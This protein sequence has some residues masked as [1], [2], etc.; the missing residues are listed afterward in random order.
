[1]IAEVVNALFLTYI[2]TE[3]TISSQ[4]SS[5]HLDH[6][7][8]VDNDKQRRTNRVLWWFVLSLTVLFI[9]LLDQVF[10]FGHVAHYILNHLPILHV[11][12]VAI[13]ALLFLTALYYD[14]RYTVSKASNS[15][16]QLDLRTD[17][18]PRVA[19]A[20][21]LIL[22][23][24][25]FLAVLISFGFLFVINIF[26][27]LRIPVELLNWPVYYGTLYGPFSYIY[28]VVK[29]DVVAE[30]TILPRRHSPPRRLGSSGV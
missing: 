13:A 1:M 25:P 14:C 21:V 18:I 3:F 29:R 7:S 6:Q 17:F 10:G 5:S 16:K 28:S 11:P 23:V 2:A 24:Y 12:K 4:S 27:F 15:K 30:M 26:E 20:F 22:P 8:N 19:R 9:N